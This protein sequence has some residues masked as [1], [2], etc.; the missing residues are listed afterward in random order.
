[1]AV[2]GARRSD[3]GSAGPDRPG[4]DTSEERRVGVRWGIFGTGDIADALTQAIR[5]EGGEVVAVSS[6]HAGR[7]AAFAE[8]HGIARHHAPHHALLDAGGVDAVYV[9]TT[10]DRHRDDAIACLEAGVPV[11]LEK[12][13]ALSEAQTRGVLTT[14]ERTGVFLMEAMW[15]RFQPGLFEL[16]R[17]IAAGQIGTPRLL[18]AHFG[19]VAEHDPTRRWFAREQGG[20]ALLDIGVYPLTFAISL[21]GTPIEAQAVGETADSAVDEQLAVAMRHTGGVS[22][23]SAS[24]VADAGVEATVAGSEG[25]FHLST[26]FHEV[27]RLLRRQGGQ[28]VEEAAVDGAGLG[29]RPEVR[30]VHR[31]LAEGLTESPRMPHAL[32]RTV[33]H[34]L[35]VLRHQLGVV[36]PGDAPAGR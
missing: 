13:F 19:I 28:D 29:Y 34:W 20:G 18:A 15:M 25:S 36:Y 11:L 9:A 17:R 24:F 2:S 32:S 30:E 12:P 3:R 21:L 16:E 10:N 6:A 33:M 8:R 5:A 7:A 14:A 26:P 22:S 4:R 27:P 35:D 1:M 23:W 31:C